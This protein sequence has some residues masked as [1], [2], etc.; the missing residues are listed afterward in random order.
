MKPSALGY[1]LEYAK[2]IPSSETGNKKKPLGTCNAFEATAALQ[3]FRVPQQRLPENHPFGF[4]LYSPIRLP[5]LK[6]YAQIRKVASSAQYQHMPR[7]TQEQS[8]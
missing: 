6:Y 4:M 1:L 2:F 8:I 3:D 5:R 7:F